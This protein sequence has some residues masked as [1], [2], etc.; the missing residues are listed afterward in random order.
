[1]YAS[2]DTASKDV[3]DTLKATKPSLDATALSRLC[4]T[5]DDA[6]LGAFERLHAGSLLQLDVVYTVVASTRAAK[7]PSAS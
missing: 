1:M 6:V 3:L 2:T 5:S 7:A 4:A